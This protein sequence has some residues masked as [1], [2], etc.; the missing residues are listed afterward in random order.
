MLPHHLQRLAQR[1]ALGIARHGTP[2]GNNSGDIFLAFSTANA[3]SFEYFQEPELTMSFV[4]D[5]HFDPIYLAAVE[6]TEEATI[7]AMLAARDM[8]TFKPRGRICHAIDHGAL[9]GV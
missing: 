4:P 8:P 1:A 2:G 5:N 7:N 3:F 6:A 9:V